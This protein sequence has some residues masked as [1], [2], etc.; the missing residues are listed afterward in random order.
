M[1][2]MYL[3]IHWVKFCNYVL[4]I[5]NSLKCVNGFLIQ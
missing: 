4:T 2:N 3:T 5:A 1:L